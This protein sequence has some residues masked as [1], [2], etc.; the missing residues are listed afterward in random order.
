MKGIQIIFSVITFLVVM[1]VSW[2]FMR[3]AKEQA[4]EIQEKVKKQM[5][6]A[7]M[8]RIKDLPKEAQPIARALKK[9]DHYV[10]CFNGLEKSRKSAIKRYFSWIK[11]PK[12]GPTGKERHVYGIY[13]IHG[14]DACKKGVTAASAISVDAKELQELEKVMKSYIVDAEMLVGVVT[15][16]KQYYKDQDYKDDKFK[17]GRKLHMELVEVLSKMAPSIKRFDQLLDQSEDVLISQRLSYFKK[18]YGE[19]IRYLTMKTRVVTKRFVWTVQREKDPEKVKKVLDEMI[20]VQKKLSA[21]FKKNET[22]IK[23]KVYYKK[24]IA[25]STLKRYVRGTR[26]L[27]TKGKL[28]VRALKA[29]AK[30]PKKLD[31]FLK[32]AFSGGFHK[33]SQVF[34]VYNRDVAGVRLTIP[35]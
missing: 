35:W 5:K 33:G 7:G 18:K 3:N 25:I 8:S 12:G 13:K 1:G 6:A 2:Y 30:D 9:Q 26:D 17:K 22:H 24:S 28:Y 29:A 10:K 27:V 4:Q 21:Y 11:D 16:M 34:D 15:K 23:E 20:A 32:K 31:R 14:L 19:K